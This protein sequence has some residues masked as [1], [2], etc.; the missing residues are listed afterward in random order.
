MFLQQNIFISDIY[1]QEYPKAINFKFNLFIIK[2]SQYI[3][4]KHLI[5]FIHLIFI[6]YTKK[7][8]FITFKTTPNL[9]NDIDVL[10]E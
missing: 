8:I 4:L 7:N 10:V 9:Y 1:I 6:L 5:E 2:K 3:I